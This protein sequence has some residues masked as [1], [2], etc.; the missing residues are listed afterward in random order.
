MALI[1]VKNWHKHQHPHWREPES[2]YD[3]PEGY[4]DDDNKT[5]SPKDRPHTSV[6]L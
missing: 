6:P 2:I 3:P 5:K 1:Q 4:I